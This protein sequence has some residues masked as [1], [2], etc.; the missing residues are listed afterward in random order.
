MVRFGEKS[1]NLWNIV[2]TLA[3][4][5]QFCFFLLLFNSGYLVFSYRGDDRGLISRDNWGLSI[6]VN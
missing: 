2:A 6:Y 3:G 1:A 4:Q 5:E